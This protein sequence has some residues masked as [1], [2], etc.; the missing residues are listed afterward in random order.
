MRASRLLSM[1]LQLQTRGRMTAQALARDFEVSVRTVYRDIDH[2]SEAGV[3]VCADRGCRGGIKLLDGFRSTLTG[4]TPAEFEALFL[5]GLPGPAAELGLGPQLGSARI[6][7]MAAS[8]AGPGA[9]RIASRFHLDP[10][11]WFR[12]RESTPHLSEIARATWAD[13]QLELT[14]RTSAGAA[15]FRVNPLGL[16]LKAGVWYLVADSSRGQRSYRV[17]EV[18]GATALGPTFRRPRAFA[19]AEYWGKAARRYESGLSR[20][21]A[22]VRLSP[23]GVRRCRLLGTHVAHAI[24]ATTRPAGGDRVQCR[25]PLESLEDAVRDLLH[26]G[27][28]AEVIGPSRLRKAVAATI[29]ALAKRYA[30]PVPS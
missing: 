26:L 12:T 19:L 1:M 23:R 10:V 16:V 2:L 7:V 13:R 11:G 27:E 28:D 17:S 6:K 21:T 9:E 15:T 22:T 25:I 5:S 30:T 14:Y 3:P 8:P 18:L 24:A 20:I 29:R 4:L